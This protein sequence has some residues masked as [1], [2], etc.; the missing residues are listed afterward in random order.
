LITDNDGINGNVSNPSI[1]FQYEESIRAQAT[2]NLDSGA[3]VEPFPSPVREG[4]LHAALINN[5]PTTPI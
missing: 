1:S 3:S 4:F 2:M 5:S